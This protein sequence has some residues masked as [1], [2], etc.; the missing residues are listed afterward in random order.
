[1]KII[2][3]HKEIIIA[4]IIGL[5]IVGYG[6]INYKQREM[7]LSK[8]IKADYYTEQLRQSNIDACL[9]SAHDVYVGD[10]NRKCEMEGLEA[11]CSMPKYQYEVIEKRW[12]TAKAE[13]LSRYK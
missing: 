3:N 8:Q 1:M 2:Y 6:L 11:D 10:W 13:C 5:A 12:E 4:F 7:Q 9:S